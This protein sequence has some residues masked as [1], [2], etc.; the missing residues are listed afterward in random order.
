[1]SFP[2]TSA[3]DEADSVAIPASGESKRASSA[4]WP[5]TGA[6]HNASKAESLRARFF[7]LPLLI[8]GFFEEGLL[9][10][11]NQKCEE[12]QRPYALWIHV[13]PRAVWRRSHDSGFR[14]RFRE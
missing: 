8:G 2:V 1:M 13:V 11:Q 10:N 5:K 9:G 4:D 14:R 7:M 3:V 6:A 12:A